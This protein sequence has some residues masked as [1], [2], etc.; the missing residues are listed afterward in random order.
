MHGVLL[1]ANGAAGGALDAAVAEAKG[2]DPLAPVTV[3]V[4]STYAG[5]ALRRRRSALGS[6]NVRFQ[7]LNRLAELLGAPVLAEPDRRPLTPAVRAE[8]VRQV[9]AADAGPFGAVAD[10]PST[11][12]ALETTFTELGRAPRGSVGR[13]ARAGRRAQAVARLY[14]D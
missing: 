4:P 3:A 2:D 1:V 8:A 7:S 6:V 9:L 5:L 11:I 12:A 10:H 13:L 14:G